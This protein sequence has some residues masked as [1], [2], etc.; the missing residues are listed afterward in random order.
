MDARDDIEKNEI[1]DEGPLEEVE[2]KPS[3]SS[4][5]SRTHEPKSS[6]YSD[7]EQAPVIEGSSERAWY[8]VHCYSAFLM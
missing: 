6:S 3:K 2:P 1:D 8:V 5:A 4:T 7:D